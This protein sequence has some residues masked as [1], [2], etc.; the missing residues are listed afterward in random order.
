ME[1]C[2]NPF[3]SILNLHKNVLCLPKIG[4]FL[5]GN[6]PIELE[7]WV[8]RRNQFE[9]W[10]IILKVIELVVGGLFV[11]DDWWNTITFYLNPKFGNF[12]AIPKPPI[13]NSCVQLCTHQK[14][15]IWLKGIQSNW[16][17]PYYHRKSY[18]RCIL[19]K[20]QC[21]YRKKPQRNS[22]KEM[23]IKW[24]FLE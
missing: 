9:A 12:G 10:H 16:T 20:K 24:G 14:V 6:V 8:S 13:S 17:V 4:F 1:N 7:T 2:N 11:T 5:N 3:H 23:I 15:Q 22:Q 21:V 19:N 18:G